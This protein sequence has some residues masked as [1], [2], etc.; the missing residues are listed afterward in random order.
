MHEN[1]YLKKLI[2]KNEKKILRNTRIYT[3][4]S[5]TEKPWKNMHKNEDVKIVENIYIKEN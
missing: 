2:Y 1:E 5:K 4:K 3:K